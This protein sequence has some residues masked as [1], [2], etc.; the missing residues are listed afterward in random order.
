MC[1]DQG[2]RIS[3]LALL[4]P[5]LSVA[6]W[7]ASGPIPTTLCQ[8]LKSPEQFHRTMV[9][10]RA[11]VVAGFEASIL[12]DKTCGSDA[13]VWFSYGDDRHTPSTATEYALISSLADIKY[14]ESL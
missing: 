11:T 1:E 4:C 12:N 10:V 3:V 8:I 6:S 13:S 5:V 14:P 7:A 2:M 9:R